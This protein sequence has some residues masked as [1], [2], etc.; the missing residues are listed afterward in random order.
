M[1]KLVVHSLSLVFTLV[2]SF[3][4]FPEFMTPSGLLILLIVNFFSTN[5][6]IEFDNS[7]KRRRK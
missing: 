2:L 6:V 4:I 5:L 7:L 1:E 3:F